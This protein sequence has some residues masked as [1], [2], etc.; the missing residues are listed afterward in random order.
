MKTM[1]VRDIRQ[2]WPEAEKALALDGEVV[3]T[4]DSKPIARII[5]FVAPPAKKG[6]VK[7]FAAATHMRWLKRI[8]KDDPPSLP[9]SD[10][11]LRATRNKGHQASRRPKK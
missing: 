7:R 6:T 9:S 11:I 8:S 1:T 2:R 10:E 3:V 4:R 5:P